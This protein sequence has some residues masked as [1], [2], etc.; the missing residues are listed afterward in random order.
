M[1][2]NTKNYDQNTKIVAT[3]G[4]ASSSYENLLELAREGVD[5]F[6][7]NFS[8]G[9]HKDHKEVIDRIVKI[10]QE[11]L[12]HV[13]ILA[14]L[15]GPKLRVGEME[16]T[17]LEVK[18]GDILTFVTE[19]C[20][21]SREKIY[22]S[23]KQFA[24]DVTVGEKVLVD[25]GKLEFEVVK[26][27]KK[28]KVELKVLFGGVLKSNKGVNLPNTKISLPSL[29]AK[30]KRD[31]EFI[32]TQP[33]N[34]IALSF[35]RSSRDLKNLKKKIQTQN[36]AAKIIAK[37]EKPE[38][39]AK[40]DKIIDASDGIMIARGDLGI[41]VPIERL[42]G[43]Q[44]MII[45]KCIRRARPVIVATQMMDSMISNPSPT[46]AE[47]TDVANAVLD[48][49]DAVMLSGETSVGIHPVLVVKAMNRIITEAEKDFHNNEIKRPVANP[50][51]ET[52]LSDGICFNS[53]RIADEVGAKAILGLTIS[54]YT[55][56]K[57]SSY[58][59]KAK[60]YIFSS[61]E[62]ILATLNLVWGVR[63]FYY[64]K[65][66]TTDETIEDVVEIL[67][68]K[69]RVKVGDILINTGSMPISERLRTN[70]LRVTL[71]K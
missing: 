56:F 36:H 57:V 19:K 51:S 43:L 44:K 25:D 29:T 8:H 64:D 7:L 35:V 47:V 54:G 68:K 46:R 27:N 31:L 55:A 40:I 33:V 17:G 13:G 58:R 1:N 21:G 5:V 20:I 67:K 16:G 52:F 26:T 15:Q 38:A 62:P 61:H 71:V 39:I 11:F 34:W 69:G 65:F 18:P 50:E 59:P 45:Q 4:P 14:D 24:K 53:G 28:N 41:E 37:I 49:A 42:P 32:L 63:S 70:M 60:I 23:Y 66:T 30:D 22:M 12:Y 2:G 3:I 9:S 6:R 48:G 10:N